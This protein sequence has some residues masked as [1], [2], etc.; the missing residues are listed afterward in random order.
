MLPQNNKRKNQPQNYNILSTYLNLSTRQKFLTL[1]ALL[2][3]IFLLVL[4]YISRSPKFPENIPSSENEKTLNSGRQT[5]QEIFNS[6]T[7]YIRKNHG[8]ILLAKKKTPSGIDSDDEPIVFIHQYKFFDKKTFFDLTKVFSNDLQLQYHIKH[9]SEESSGTVLD[10]QFEID[11]LKQNRLWARIELKTKNAVIL[12][13][14]DPGYADLN[15]AEE[16]ASKENSLEF[17]D[18][19]LVIIID[20]LGNNMPVFQKL[21]ELNHD[22]TFSV[23]PHQSKSVQIAEL[24]HKNGRE[25]MLHLPMQPIEWPK[26][27]PGIGALLLDDNS[28][29]VLDK[30]YASLDSVPHAVGTNNHMGSAYIQYK[31]GLDLIMEV[32]S[33]RKMFFLD[34]KTAPGKLALNSAKEHQV[35]Y[36]ARDIFI[37]NVQ[38]EQSIVTQ[39]NKAIRLVEKKGKAIVIGHPY[40]ITYQALVKYLPIIEKMGIRIVRASKVIK[41]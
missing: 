30:L 39:L 1:I 13:S 24:A 41:I 23:L 17:K 2:G 11:F 10:H 36:L 25:V 40:P 27:N 15:E 29:S 38:D 8:G 18:K 6:F 26:Y 14:P 22:I 35:A 3:I 19:Q 16:T 32:L 7:S 20:D 5:Q 9:L 34:S 4:I 37:D 28:Q 21:V 33:S 12:D 31:E